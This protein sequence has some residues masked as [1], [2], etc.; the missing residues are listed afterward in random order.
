MG[1]SSCQ[2][3]T[4]PLRLGILFTE[5]LGN[6]LDIQTFKTEFI[7]SYMSDPNLRARVRQGLLKVEQLHS[8][9]RDVYYGRRGRINARELHEQMNSC[10]CLTLILAC[11]IY[12]QAKEISRVLQS[13]D[14]KENNVDGSLLEHVSPIEWDNVIL[15]GQYIVDR[16]LVR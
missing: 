1:G 12:W 4:S 5:V 14:L 8:L 16:S 6:S 7:L 10:S 9:A 11:I 15:Y 13:Y 2:S 3:G